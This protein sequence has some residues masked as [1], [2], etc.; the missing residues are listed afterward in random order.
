MSV[1]GVIGGTGLNRI[2]GVTIAETRALSTPWGLPSAPAQ[3]LV[4]SNGECWFLPRHGEGH[5]IAPHRINYRANI[6]ALA[7]LG[8]TDVL[9]V[10]AVGG[11]DP[12]NRPGDLA[13]PE[14]LIDYTWGRAHTFAD[15]VEAPLRHVE[16]APPFDARWRRRVLSAAGEAGVTL[17]DRAILGVTQGPRLE[18]AAEIRRLARDGC[19]LVGMTSMPEAALAVEAGLAYSILAVVVNPAAGTVDGSIHAAI[20]ASL[21]AGMVQVRRLLDRLVAVHG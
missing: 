14:D 5:T 2:D 18:T 9:S 16:F 10:A 20:E 19:T 4:W 17:D 15:G 3:R 12:A 11:I 1:L 13:L 21:D 6:H 7:M 8:V